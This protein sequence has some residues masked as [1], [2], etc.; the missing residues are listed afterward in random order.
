MTDA[1]SSGD[2]LGL[3]VW[4]AIAEILH[5]RIHDLPE[6]ARDELQHAADALRDSANAFLSSEKAPWPLYP[7]AREMALAVL[8]WWNSPTDDHFAALQQASRR[9]AASQQAL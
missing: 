3:A 2:D 6:P 8:D 7:F 5:R 4:D 9:F 1:E